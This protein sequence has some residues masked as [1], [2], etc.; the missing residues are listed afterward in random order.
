MSHGR[1]V[2][3]I[4]SVLRRSGRYGEVWGR[5]PFTEITAE[6]SPWSRNSLGELWWEFR[7]MAPR[8]DRSVSFDALFR[9]VDLVAAPAGD[10]QSLDCSNR[11]TR[12]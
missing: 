10:A 1:L 11:E 3:R 12:A 5:A 6:T 8:P 4:T 2:K 7:D 9:G